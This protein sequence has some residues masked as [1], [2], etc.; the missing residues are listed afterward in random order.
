MPSSAEAITG[1]P[2]SRVP[3]SSN[4]VE[5]RDFADA[6][7]TTGTTAVVRIAAD[8]KTSVSFNVPGFTTRS[9]VFDHKVSQWRA[10]H[11]VPDRNEIPPGGVLQ[12]VH[13]PFCGCALRP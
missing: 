4:R 6:V 13:P 2:M 10:E 12:P 7:K 11:F 3:V 5:S 9:M 8:M 1:A